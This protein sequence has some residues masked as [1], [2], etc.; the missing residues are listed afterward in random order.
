MRDPYQDFGMGLTTKLRHNFRVWYPKFTSL[1]W[2]SSPLSGSTPLISIHRNNSSLLRYESV[3]ICSF[4]TIERL[5]KDILNIAK[6]RERLDRKLDR[7]DERQ[8]K[9]GDTMRLT[10]LE[11]MAKLDQIVKLEGKL[12]QAKEDFREHLRK[13][14]KIELEIVKLEGTVEENVLEKERTSSQGLIYQSDHLL[15]A[16]QRIQQKLVSKNFQVRKNKT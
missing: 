14:Y 10:D 15:K 4:Q 16:Y 8:D 5:R 11:K 13:V 3:S 1:R 2:L 12:V 9:Q 7:I 6:E